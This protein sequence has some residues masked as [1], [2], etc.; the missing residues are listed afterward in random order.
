MS[1]YTMKQKRTLKSSALADILK[2]VGSLS[3]R[4]TELKRYYKDMQSLKDY[5]KSLGLSYKDFQSLAPVD[6]VNFWTFQ[7]VTTDKDGKSHSIALK[8]VNK[9]SETTDKDGKK[10]LI[11]Y[12]FIPVEKWSISMVLTS[13]LNKSNKDFKVRYFDTDTKYID[14]NKQPVVYTEPTEQNTTTEQA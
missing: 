8:R 7:N 14:V 10:T 3:N 5:V 9:W 13:M 12:Y 2:F 11:Y 6:I 4:L 1:T